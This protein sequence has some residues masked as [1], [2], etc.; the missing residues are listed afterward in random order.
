MNKLFL[1]QL[2]TCVLGL[3][4]SGPIL[5]DFS[6]PHGVP[7]PNDTWFIGD[8]TESVVD[9]LSGTA[10]ESWSIAKEL[11]HPVYYIDNTSSDATNSNNEFG[12]PDKPRLSIPETT[13]EA[14]SYIEIHGG[15]YDGGGQIIFTGNGNASQ[16]IWF[17]GKSA[18][19]KGNIN[20]QII[21]KGQYIFF[22]N[23]EFTEGG[24]LSLRTHK[25]STISNVVV[26]NSIFHGDGTV[27][28]NGSAISIYSTSSDDRFHDFVVYQNEIYEMGNDFNDVD[29]AL[30]LS[31][32]NDVHGIHPDINVDRVW[33][34][35]NKIHNMGG[36]SIQIGRAS[37]SDENRAN[38]IYVAGNEFYS[39]L[40]NAVDIKKSDYTLIIDNKIYDW[41]QHVGNSSTGTAIVIHNG[42]TNSWIVNNEITDAANGISATGGSSEVW[43][44]GNYISQ[45]KHPN[46]D[47]DWSSQSIY[48]SGSAIHFRGG[49][50]GGAVN[51]TLM[52]IDKPIESAEGGSQFINNIIYERN[53]SSSYD[54]NIGSSKVTNIIKNNLIYH[55]NESKSL[56]NATCTSCLYDEPKFE[57]GND[58]VYLTETN[59]S[60]IGAGT[61]IDNILTQFESTFGTE[62]SL[63]IQGGLRVFGDIDIGAYENPNSSN[64]SFTSTPEAPSS[65]G[66]AEN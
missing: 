26:R 61:S 54:I 60:V 27:D 59:S 65:V 1:S 29:T 55:S 48:S 19:D 10:P 30:G 58:V 11:G 33:V 57:T 39:N 6:L 40:E 62:L 21:A 16:P 42:A 66:V 52:Y 28:G 64:T 53:E 45:I 14:G 47:T 4:V 5:A 34:L 36:D 44:L 2:L 12:S 43:I 17:R 31:E 13:F 3:V 49:S 20:G 18:D 56:K 8:S 7:N 23:L 22:E 32:E 24:N 38:Y 25:S 15:P 63:D 50:Y 51:N 9:P 46:W 37:T 41:R 35:N